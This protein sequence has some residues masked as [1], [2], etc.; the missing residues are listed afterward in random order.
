VSILCV[1][2]AVSSNCGAELV[3]FQPRASNEALLLGVD[4]LDE[5]GGGNEVALEACP[6]EDIAR[7]QLW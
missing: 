7:R 5:V 6:C 4:E 2:D 1:L 3:D